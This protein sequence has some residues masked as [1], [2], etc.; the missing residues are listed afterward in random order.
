ML[1]KINSVLDD[2]LL[3]KSSDKEE[4]IYDALVRIQ[5]NN[6]GFNE[7][8]ELIRYIECSYKHPINFRHY[9]S[10]GTGGDKFKTINISTMASI[11]ASNFVNIWKVGTGAVTS[12]WGSSD[13]V[14]RLNL[15]KQSYPLTLHEKNKIS[16]QDGSG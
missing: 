11:L 4:E 6:L 14:N 16:Y 13:F 15:F 5:P 7:I 10:F 3:T 9:N 12:K 1:I 2:F 8:L